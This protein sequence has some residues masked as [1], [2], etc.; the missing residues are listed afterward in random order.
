MNMK[1]KVIKAFVEVYF[2]FLYLIHG[3]IK[4]YDESLFVFF[5]HF[6]LCE[7]YNIFLQ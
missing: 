4:M 5:I 3:A 6:I 7:I 1:K 2:S